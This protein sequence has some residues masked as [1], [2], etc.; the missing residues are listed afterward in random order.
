MSFSQ[1]V[2][3][4]FHQS[5]QRKERGIGIPEAIFQVFYTLVFAAAENKRT[6]ITIHFSLN[7]DI[8]PANLDRKEAFPKGYV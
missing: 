8:S 4:F 3:D 5:K 6:I 7:N 2:L 1:I